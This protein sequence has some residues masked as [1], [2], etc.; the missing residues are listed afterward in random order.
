MK[1][2]SIIKKISNWSKTKKLTASIYYPKNIAEL[3]NL[4]NYL[5]EN[6]IKF[7]IMGSGNS[8]GDCF[9]SR[10][11]INLKNFN[12]IINFDKKKLN[13]TVESGVKLK[14][15]LN[16]LIPN[17]FIINSLPGTFN[18]TVG[19]CIGSNVHGK[20][21]HTNGVFGSNIIELK[22]LNKNGKIET[23]NK[24]HKDFLY[25]IGTFGLVNIILEIKLEITP[26]PSRS[27]KVVT[28]KF[29]NLSQMQELFEY[30][31]KNN[32]IYLGSWIDHFKRD[33]NGIFK[34]ATWELNDDLSFNYKKIK[35]SNIF[36]N[37]F[38]LTII[39]FFPK[40]LF[41]NRYTIKFLNKLLFIFTR[42][43]T[44]NNIQFKDFYYPQENNL[45]FESKLFNGG[46]YNIQI[47]IPKKNFIKIMNSIYNICKQYGYESWWAGIKKHK[48]E[49][50]INNF[51]L[52]GYDLTLQWSGK[53]I[54]KKKFKDFYD[55]LIQIIKKNNCLIYFTQDV[56]LN[57]KHISGMYSNSIEIINKYESRNIS[58][59]NNM[60]RRII[61]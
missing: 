1:I 31:K 45:P 9:M 5:T 4:Q 10:N 7:S 56:L 20:D 15:L 36:V 26:I 12:K 37:E 48:E 61:N 49:N 22:I 41:V 2:T 57:S 23:I 8:Y 43:S 32:F 28:K 47:L 52:D 53:Y 39:Y 46:K 17:N 33:S 40:Y 34:A 18:A 21:S 30:Y 38:F 3:I 11:I 55:K 44:K 58:L 19:G 6:N 13:I 16:L 24:K 59:E 14:D 54:K 51:A 42:N 50:Y 25:T 27:L 29:F 60:Y 35:K